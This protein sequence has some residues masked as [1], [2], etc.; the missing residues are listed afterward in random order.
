MP[1]ARNPLPRGLC[2]MLRQAVQRSLEFT[3]RQYRRNGRYPA[4]GCRDRAGDQTLTERRGIMA[5][6]TSMTTAIAVIVTKT[7]CTAEAS[8]AG[9]G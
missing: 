4:L 5:E 2:R 3:D 1:T 7:R 9:S 6:A 8:V